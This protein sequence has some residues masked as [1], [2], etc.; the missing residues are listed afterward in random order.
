[1]KEKIAA[2]VIL[3][4]A[5]ISSFGCGAS[6]EFTAKPVALSKPAPEAAPVPLENI[7]AGKDAAF[8]F[9][10][11]KYDPLSEDRYLAYVIEAKDRDAAALAK[12]KAAALQRAVAEAEAQLGT[13]SQQ[14]VLID[15]NPTNSDSDSSSGDSGGSAGDSVDADEPAPS[16]NERYYN[17][18]AGYS[19]DFP[20]GW[21]IA[22]DELADFQLVAAISP[23]VGNTSQ[24]L[25][26]I[27]VAVEELPL[28]LSSE[29]YLDMCV[30]GFKATFDDFQEV[31]RSDFTLDGR[32][33]RKMVFT[34]N[35]DGTPM[36]DVLYEVVKGSK[37][38]VIAGAAEAA[39]YSEYEGRFDAT[40]SSFKFE[41]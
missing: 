34:F 26:T 24:L 25:E 28:E 8:V 4:I 14:V 18:A 22:D 35:N 17:T 23:P 39:T 21:V 36:K 38:Y 32:T 3:L 40:A 37:A 16:S 31:S 30:L 33:G 11:Q 20:D 7:T 6:K 2:V 1:M 9:A 10:A 27:G 13:S 19:I 15:T 41:N 5:V 29:E 12:E